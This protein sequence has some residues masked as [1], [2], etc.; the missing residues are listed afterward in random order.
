VFRFKLHKSTDI[1]QKLDLNEV[2]SVLIQKSFA[3][4]QRDRTRS[5]WL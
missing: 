3:T 4:A 2:V 5:E 1:E